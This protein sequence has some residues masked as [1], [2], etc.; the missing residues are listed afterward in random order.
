LYLHFSPPF[1][2]T[3]ISTSPIVGGDDDGF[4]SGSTVS[5]KT[6][7]VVFPMSIHLEGENNIT[8]TYGRNDK[9]SW[10]VVLD[11]KKALASL[12]VVRPLS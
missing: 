7:Y 2:I 12:E 8:I 5:S 1:Y 3:G 10:I 6:N 11:R 4:Y 9:D